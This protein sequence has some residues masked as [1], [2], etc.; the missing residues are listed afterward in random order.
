[1]AS[2][3]DLYNTIN[4]K[5][6]SNGLLKR[7]I[8]TILIRTVS[9]A[10]MQMMNSDQGYCFSFIIKQKNLNSLMDSLSITEKDLK[11]A[12]LKDWGV[13]AAKN[14]MHSNLYYQ[15]YLLM[16]Y[17]GVKQKDEKIINNSMI[18]IL[19]KLWN[20]RK[21]KYLP[22]CN[23]DIMSYVVNYMTSKKHSIHKFN[24]PLELI[25]NYYTPTL[26][27]IYQGSINTKGSLGLK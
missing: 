24:N 19:M 27:S 21:K 5:I 22:Y 13:G 26:L 12:Y 16:L 3:N 25:Q 10:F 14:H 9:D 6:S 23:K 17:Y 7:Q 2:V 20:G 15:V 11:E 1:V 4:V 18:C 8:E